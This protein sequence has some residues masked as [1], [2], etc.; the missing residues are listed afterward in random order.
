MSRQAKR[1]VLD[2][3]VRESVTLDKVVVAWMNA[4]RQRVLWLDSSST[5]PSFALTPGVHRVTVTL[6]E[7]LCPAPGEYFLNVAL[8]GAGG[9]VDYVADA[10]RITI[11]QG[12]FFG[13]GKLPPLNAAMFVDHEWK[14]E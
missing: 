1:V 13:T 14:V 11:E 5:V 9:R 3:D 4:E 8:I 7:G 10:L 12:D 2:V 6:R